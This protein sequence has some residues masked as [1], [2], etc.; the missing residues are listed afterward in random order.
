MTR[1]YC[2]WT[3]W[4]IPGRTGD[5]GEYLIEKRFCYVFNSHMF[6]APRF[7]SEKDV[8]IILFTLNEA[9]TCVALPNAVRTFLVL[10][11]Q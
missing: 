11:Q 5:N 2:K 3:L 9:N 7:N 8:S 6:N 4:R 1:M 10:S